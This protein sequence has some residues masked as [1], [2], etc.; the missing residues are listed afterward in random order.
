MLCQEM[1]TVE[2]LEPALHRR[3]PGAH[4]RGQATFVADRVRRPCQCAGD[5]HH[6]SRCTVVSCS[7]AVN[8]RSEEHD[9]LGAPARLACA[10]LMRE[11]L[12]GFASV[13]VA[14]L[15]LKLLSEEV[16]DLR[17]YC[18]G[19]P[20]DTRQQVQGFFARGHLEIRPTGIARR[21]QH[22]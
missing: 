16:V 7:S 20:A 2:P 14:S 9:V 22:A 4:G 8:G 18:A 21:A 19:R 6:G 5:H 10:Q 12:S 3:A 11:R 15:L 17:L 13:W 1:M